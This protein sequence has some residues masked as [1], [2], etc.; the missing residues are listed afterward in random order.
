MKYIISILIVLSVFIF[1]HKLVL[2]EDQV[3]TIDSE[4]T[5]L[6]KQYLVNEKKAR[7]IINCESQMYAK[8]INENKNKDGKVWS[9]DFGPWQVNDYW[10]EKTMEKKGLDIHDEF[11]SLEYGFM[12]ISKEGDR[13]WKASSKCWLTKI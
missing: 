11:D 3:R 1:N 6:A 5:R 12:L 13:H 2:A 8:A 7:E 10:H 4:I 9:R